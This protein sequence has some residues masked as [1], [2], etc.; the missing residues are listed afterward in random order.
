MSQL[1]ERQQELIGQEISEQEAAQAENAA[2]QMRGVADEAERATRA[3]RQKR[4]DMRQTQRQ[5]REKLGEIRQK[6]GDINRQISVA[7]ME[8]GKLEA[9]AE[10]L[11]Q[12]R[13]KGVNLPASNG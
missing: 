2:Q 4:D 11:D 9:R 12:R 6:I 1:R 8:L 13:L 5:I 10:L 7:H 3:L